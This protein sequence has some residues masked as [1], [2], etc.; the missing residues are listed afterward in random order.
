MQEKTKL[1]IRA[2]LVRAGRSMAQAMLT[3]IGTAM[4]ISDVDW[5]VFVSNALLMGLASI[6]TSLSGL[7]EVEMQ[8]QKKV[9]ADKGEE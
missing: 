2:A 7:P 5:R 8:I 3:T 6:L 4:V 9:E 1:W